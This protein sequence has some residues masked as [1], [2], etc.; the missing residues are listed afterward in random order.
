MDKEKYGEDIDEAYDR[1]KDRISI[2]LYEDLTKIW[3][4]YKNHIYFKS[5][6]KRLLNWMTQDVN[7]I[8]N[9]EIRE[10]V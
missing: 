6:P 9:R 7:L 8:C 3:N 10:N 5:S 1:E 2:E 4:N